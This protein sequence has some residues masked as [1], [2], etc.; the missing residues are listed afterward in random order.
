VEFTAVTWKDA[1]AKSRV[2]VIETP[3]RVVPVVTRDLMNAPDSDVLRAALRKSLDRVPLLA[4]PT[5]R[6]PERWPGWR[7]HRAR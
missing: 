3:S 2:S 5:R 4:S 1:A 6:K 7:G